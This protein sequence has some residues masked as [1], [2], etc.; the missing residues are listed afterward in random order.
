MCHFL[1][2][3][4]SCTWGVCHYICYQC[5]A[6][7]TTRTDIDDTSISSAHGADTPRAQ[8]LAIDMPDSDDN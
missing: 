5:S 6:L 1:I 2:R 3:I 7:Y 8:D 4:T